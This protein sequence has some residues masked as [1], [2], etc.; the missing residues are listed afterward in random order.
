LLFLFMTVVSSAFGSDS[1]RTE[2]RSCCPHPFLL[3]TWPS[4]FG[5]LARHSLQAGS[6]HVPT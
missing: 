6:A 3:V 5:F 4:H 2:L 1:A